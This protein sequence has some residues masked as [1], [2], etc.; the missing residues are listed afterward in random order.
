M[1][2]KGRESEQPLKKHFE[3]IWRIRYI[4]AEY[5]KR[6]L[7]SS[8]MLKTGSLKRQATYCMQ[9][10]ANKV[11]VN[12]LLIHLVFSSKLI[13]SISYEIGHLSVLEAN[14]INIVH[15]VLLSNVE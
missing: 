2:L 3:L 15:L 7:I 10:P 11:T 6:K 5:S 12:R 13:F 4:F 14:P 8:K 9:A 1:V